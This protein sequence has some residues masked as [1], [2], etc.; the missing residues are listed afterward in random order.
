[1]KIVWSP[2]VV[3]SSLT[4]GIYFTTQQTRNKPKIVVDIE[5]TN[6]SKLLMMYDPDAATPFIH[7]ITTLSGKDILPYY[8]PSPPQKT[9]IHRYMFCLIS[10]PPSNNN[11]I[12]NKIP[13]CKSMFY[14]TS[15][16]F[17]KSKTRKN[18][19]KVLYTTL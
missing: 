12:L 18:K 2:S 1:M 17:I 3:L 9:G 10:S 14:F 19:P 16:Y 15:K 11:R 7:W 5:N 8:P 4:N 13:S 6:S